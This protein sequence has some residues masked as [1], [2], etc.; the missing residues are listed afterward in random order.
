MPHILEK[1]SDSVIWAIVPTIPAVLFVCGMDVRVDLNPFY[2]VSPGL[3]AG[4]T[5]NMMDNKNPIA[6]T[7]AGE[8]H[9]KLAGTYRS[10]HVSL[11]CTITRKASGA[12]LLDA[13]NGRK[14]NMTRILALTGDRCALIG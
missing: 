2:P 9:H 3:P 12:V 11:A 6:I 5:E 1:H 14:K 4:S 7:V 10:I 13:A 8:F